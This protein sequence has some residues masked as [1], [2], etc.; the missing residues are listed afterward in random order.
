[1]GCEERR[2]ISRTLPPMDLSSSVVVAPL[3]ARSAAP[4][5]RAAPRAR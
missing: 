1:L 5:L 3:R 2:I 4:S